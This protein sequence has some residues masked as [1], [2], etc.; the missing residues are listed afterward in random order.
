M[1]L[2]HDL[3][4]KLKVLWNHETALETYNF[5]GILSEALS[6]SQLQSSAEV[7]YSNV[8]SLGSN[9]IFFND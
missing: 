4:V 9:D 2:V 8:R 7:T 5:I 1:Y 6:F 3:A